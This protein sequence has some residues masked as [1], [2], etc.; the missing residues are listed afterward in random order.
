MLGR[1]LIEASVNSLG[2]QGPDHCVT[3][4]A[5]RGA[6]ARVEAVQR[7]DGETLPGEVAVRLP[8]QAPGPH[9]LAGHS[10]PAPAAEACEP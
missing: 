4:H 8:D 9:L 3:G 7:S 1:L 10:A 5:E 2:E 6:P